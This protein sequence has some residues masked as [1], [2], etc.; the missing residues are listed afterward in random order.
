MTHYKMHG[1]LA[2]LNNTPSHVNYTKIIKLINTEG[3]FVLRHG[4]GSSVISTIV[5]KL[6][7]IC[8]FI[9]MRLF[10][11]H[12]DFRF[13]ECSIGFWLSKIAFLRSQMLLHTQMYDYLF[14]VRII[15][16]LN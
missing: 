11:F 1:S 6:Y 8:I 10:T 9:Q 16:F 5:T 14:I 4:L 15:D 2:T 3:S 7:H 13:V 12:R